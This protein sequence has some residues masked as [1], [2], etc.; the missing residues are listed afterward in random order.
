MLVVSGQQTERNCG[1][2]TV[3]P[4]AI[5]AAEESTALVRL[6]ILELRSQV[7]QLARREQDAVQTLYH[8]VRKAQI[9]VRKKYVRERFVDIFGAHQNAQ[10]ADDERA[11]LFEQVRIRFE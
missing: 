9:F 6:Q 4:G 1:D 2:G 11:T 3:T 7:E 5:Q 10:L 8:H